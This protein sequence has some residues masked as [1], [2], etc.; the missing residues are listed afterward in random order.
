[1]PIGQ[2]LLIAAKIGVGLGIGGALALSMVWL[3]IEGW[4]YV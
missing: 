1:M 4:K 3:F 2:A